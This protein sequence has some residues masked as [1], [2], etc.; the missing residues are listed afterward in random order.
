MRTP[1][2]V[3]VI[4]A[5]AY[6]RFPFAFLPQVDEF[7]MSSSRSYDTSSRTDFARLEGIHARASRRPWH[8][9]DYVFHF[10]RRRHGCY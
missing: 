3:D 9:L 5:H 8:V 2:F 10:A 1:V 6:V 7:V 4:T